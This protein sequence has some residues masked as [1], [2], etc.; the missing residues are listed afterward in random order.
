MADHTRAWFTSFAVAAVAAALAF[1]P[2]ARAQDSDGDGFPDASDN[3][4]TIANPNQADCDQDGVGNACELIVDVTTSNMGAFGA[5]VNANGTL[6]GMVRSATTVTVT[7]E[8]KADLDLIGEYATISIGGTAMPS[9]FFVAGGSFC[10]STLDREVVTLT[11]AQWNA[12]IDANPSGNLAVQVVGSALVSAT[13]CASPHISVAVRYGN[14]F[15]A[16]DCNQNG[17]PDPTDIANGSA[18]DCNANAVPDSCDIASGSADEDFDTRI[19]SCEYAV[20]DF[21]LNGAIDSFDLAIVLGAWGQATPQHGDLDGD[22]VVGGGD[23]A[24]LFARWGRVPAVPPVVFG[25]SPNFGPIKGGTA[26]TISGVNLLDATEVTVGGVAATNV[27]VVSDGTITAVTGEPMTPGLA[28]LAFTTPAGSMAMEGAFNYG[29]SPPS[30]ATVLEWA[31]NASIVTNASL[32]AAISATDLPWR[33]RDNASNIEML[34][35]PPG[36]FN[37]GCSASASFGC[38]SNENPIHQVTLT[39][40]FYIGKTEVTQAQ[41]QA[42]MGYQPSYFSGSPDSASR[43]VE[44]VQWNTI[45]SFLSQN[46][47]RL[48]TEAEWEY[49]YRAG[50]TTAFHS[51]PMFPNGTASDLELA[52]IAWCSSNSGWQTH[53]VARKAANALGL[54]DMA[55][56]V[57]EWVNDYWGDYPSDSPVIDPQGPAGGS[58]YRVIR[59]GGWNDSASSCRASTR[60]GQ[61]ESNPSPNIGFRV[62]RTP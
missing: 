62:A 9:S 33:V 10:P 1:A 56:N 34:L 38:N 17:I 57:S 5:G 15:A 35:V 37:M 18:L 44:Q 40:A 6:T 48:P 46:A 36:T 39:S 32:R 4:P 25:V 21:D 24:E 55:G 28:T 12:I 29:G 11:I 41:W 43:P 58:Y 19:D 52:S 27:V 53:P 51:A 23:L 61:H 59:G 20:G 50:T 2:T 3:C 30:W 22:G 26:I 7:V 47:L 13:E 49:A 42:E 54:H 45:P 60:N 14:I 31:P 16:C 8:A